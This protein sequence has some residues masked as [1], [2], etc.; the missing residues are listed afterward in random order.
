[1]V[2]SLHLD[3]GRNA[4][5]EEDE[6]GISSPTGSRIKGST[7]EMRVML[8]EGAE[9]GVSSADDQGLSCL[10]RFFSRDSWFADCITVQDRV[11]ITIIQKLDYIDHS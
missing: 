4:S 1:M 2:Q 7:G 9:V 11:E 6:E 3:G 10:S 5:V 8:A